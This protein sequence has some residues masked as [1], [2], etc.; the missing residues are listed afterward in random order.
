VDGAAAAGQTLD[1]LASRG[2]THLLSRTI[3][4]LNDSDGHADKRTRSVLVERFSSNGMPVM[5]LPFDGN[6]RHGGVIEGTRDMSTATR[7]RFVEIAAAL[8]DHFP[9]SDDRNRERR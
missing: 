3:L 4:V 5:E 6:L 2:M 9:T 1:W 7:S 8:A